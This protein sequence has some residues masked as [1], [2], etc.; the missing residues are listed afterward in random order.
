MVVSGE[1]GMIVQ[2]VNSRDGL[3]YGASIIE[4]RKQIIIRNEFPADVDVQAWA[5]A[6]GRTTTF[7]IL[8]EAAVWRGAMKPFT[9]RP[10]LLL[11]LANSTRR[12]TGAC[13]QA[14]HRYVHV[15]SQ[16]ATR[17]HCRGGIQKAGE[18]LLSE[19]VGPAPSRSCKQS[20]S[21][22]LCFRNAR[23]QEV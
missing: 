5:A 3:T 12:V 21:G 7:D 2:A 19:D 13:Q 17:P 6:F 18:F 15:R 1:R 14:N 22:N 4:K 9:V 11:E 16:S 10:L 23:A 8:Y 20:A